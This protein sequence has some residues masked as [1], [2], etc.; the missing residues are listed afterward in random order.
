MRKL[1]SKLSLKIGVFIII[2]QFIGLFA[3]GVFFINSL[4]NEVETR[5]ENQINTPGQLMSEG[6]LDY[7]AA[8]NAEI[9]E[10][11][12][13][14]TISDCIVVGTDGSVFYSFAPEYQ[15]KSFNEIEKYRPFPELMKELD[16]T[17]FKR[18]EVAGNNF[19]A[20]ISSIRLNDGKWLGNILIIAQNDKVAK[21]K[22]WLTIIIVVGSIVCLVITSI[23][24]LFLFNSFI[25][26]KI[27]V[28][29]RRLNRLKDGILNAK[30]TDFDSKDE[31]GL[32]WNSINDVSTNLTGIVNDI[33]QN[34]DELAKTSVNIK[35]I[36][37]NIANG[38]NEQSTSAE[39][40][41]SLVE[42]LVSSIENNSENANRTETVSLKTHEG[43]LRMASEAQLSLK[44]IREIAEKITIIN[45]IAFQ[46]NLLALNAAV[47]AARAGEHGKGFS[48]VA[49][50]VRKLAERSKG[51]ADEI[52]KLAHDC[53]SITENSHGLMNSLIPE[54]EN[55][56]ALIKEIAGSSMEQK[57]GV[58][59]ISDAI[60]QLNNIIQKNSHM[61]DTLSAYSN[62]LEKDSKRL[63]DKV[64][65]FRIE[66]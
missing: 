3:L 42:E 40:V 61:A 41:L 47:E 38:S 30:V 29:V 53:V 8:E 60:N 14:E 63:W 17:I 59:Q 13:G 25:T 52:I 62:H 36:S 58:N 43:I 54:I 35:D 66:K 9:L 1:N 57:L 22:A 32:I 34:S 26:R 10:D 55:T 4:V 50:E 15:E 18:F 49:Q 12:V 23:V 65:F 20:G 7:E 28:V 6:A 46:T 39:E 51:A 56:K 19:Y 64:S 33:H 24:I 27:N 37:K 48:V 31:I 45:D 2:T 11:I 5:I 21:Q 44:Y 16:K